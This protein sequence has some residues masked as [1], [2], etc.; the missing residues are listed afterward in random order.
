MDG[1]LEI[2]A[3]L[4][5][6]CTHCQQVC[7][8]CN[9]GIDVCLVLELVDQGRLTEAV[10][11]LLR[12]NPLPAVAGR[13]CP[14][15]C[16]H[17]V[18]ALGQP[19]AKRYAYQHPALAERFPEHEGKISVRD[20][21]AFLGDYALRE[22]PPEHFLPAL[23]QDG[24]A[25]VVGSG[26]S[27]LSAAWQL[28]RRGWRVVVLDG[29][30]RP[31]GMLRS[32]IPAFRL[33][34]EILDGEIGRL[35]GIGVEFRCGIRVGRD[36]TLAELARDFDAVILAVGDGAARTLTLPGA[37]AVE[38]GLMNGLEFLARYNTGRAPPVGERV[39]IV[40]GGNTAIDCARAAVR[41]DAEA[42]VLYRRAEEDMP[43]IPDEVAEAR[44]E[45]VRFAFQRLPVRVV[46][47]VDGHIAGVVTVE[48]RPGEPDADGRRRPVAVPGTERTEAFDLL[49]LAVGEAADLSFLEGTELAGD[50]AS[51]AGARIP[52]NFAG[53]THQAGVFACGDAAFG[54][55]TV[56]QAIATGRRA[57]ELAAEYMEKNATRKP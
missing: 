48:M 35:Q 25:V 21:E 17:D 49:V 20:V 14:H 18:N 51:A 1:R 16:D 53:A 55:G 12:A 4:C 44:K 3:S 33:P 29:A 42:V 37:D 6:G 27:G 39:A 43:A 41:L 28:R 36:V 15:P 26:P 23:E 45:R 38:S 46:A 22:L 31:G 24:C 52:V 50:A 8:D 56:T 34:R 13:V 2:N 40:G 10:D 57:A 7:A 54:Q 47:G 5:T 9:A 11:V 19:Q 30:A 32:G